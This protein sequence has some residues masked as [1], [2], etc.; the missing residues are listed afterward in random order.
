MAH[1]SLGMAYFY[2]GKVKEAHASLERAVE[3]NSQNYLAHYYYAF[4][5]SRSAT[6]DAPV[7]GYSPDVAAKIR[8]HL[9]KAIALRP[10]YLESYNLLAFVS[11]VTGDGID[12]AIASMKSVLN[13]VRGRRDFML[14]LAQLYMRKQDFKTSRGLLEQI[15]KMNPT[16]EERQH[17]EQLLNYINSYES[18]RT[19]AEEANKRGGIGD[20]LVVTTRTDSAPSAPQEPQDPSSYLREALR[21]PKPDETRLQATIVKIEC[22]A[23]GIVFVVQSGTRTLRLLTKTFDEIDLTTYDPK[24]GGEITCGPRK[25]ETSVV[26]CYVP[27]TDKKLGADGVL[28]SVEFVPADFKL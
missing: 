14:M 23:K 16:E 3:A 24:S 20:P 1:A 9:Q 22:S 28:K 15:V 19:Q 18:A 27:S 6:G 12:D 8:E 4:T 2:E 13:I 10:D 25:A 7:T 26:V 17:A 5:L 11:V 21:K